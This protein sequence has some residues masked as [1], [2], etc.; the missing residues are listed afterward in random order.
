M[1]HNHAGHVS[2]AN[3]SRLKITLFIVLTIMVVEAIGSLLSNSLA[4]LSDAGHM[5]VDALALGI[6]LFAITIARKPATMRRTFG[7]HRIE[8]MAALLN[9]AILLVLSGYI[10]FE[11]YQRFLTP[12]EVRAPLMLAVAIIGLV[13]NIIGIS[14]L[15]KASLGSLNIKAAFWHILGDTISSVGVIAAAIIIGVTGWTTADAIIA[16]FIG[17]IILWGAIMVVRE[18]ADILLETVP[19]HINPDDVVAA[20]TSIPGVLEVHD[21]HIWTITSGVYALS[22][23][24]LIEDQKVSRSAEI[25]TAVE[26]DLASR[27]NVT[28][29]TL[30][31]ECD[32]CETCPD[33][34]I[35]DIGKLRSHAHTH[36]D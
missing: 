3:I 36:E 13:A 4:L 32:R 29:T 2:E 9:G 20:L 21:L 16:S 35:C 19:K 34:F 12:H 5:L 33:G 18:S 31:L 1:A 11:A 30:Q 24:L 28:H 15:R 23:H 26:G 7:Y 8:I 22:A 17:L 10:F 6:S 25:R 14:L 27:F